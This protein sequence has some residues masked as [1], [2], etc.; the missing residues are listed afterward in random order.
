MNVL[1]LF[2]TVLRLSFFSLLISGK[3]TFTTTAYAIKWWHCCNCGWKLNSQKSYPCKIIH[4]RWQWGEMGSPYGY[5]GGYISKYGNYF[6][7]LCIYGLSNIYSACANVYKCVG[8][9]HSQLQVFRQMIF[10]FYMFEVHLT[11]LKVKWE[12]LFILLFLVSVMIFK[13]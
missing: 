11:Q 7:S 12:L 9:S 1:M 8:Y 6:F 3:F 4:V 2:Q 5:W 10:L 13:L